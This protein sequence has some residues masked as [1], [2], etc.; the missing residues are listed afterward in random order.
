V[1]PI[2]VLGAADAEQRARGLRQ[3]EI[4]RAHRVA[5]RRDDGRVDGGVGKVGRIGVTAT[6]TATASS[7]RE[8]DSGREHVR[9]NH[10]GSV[11]AHACSCHPEAATSPPTRTGVDATRRLTHM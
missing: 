11:P 6:A 4:G 10:G 7:Q 9:A 2:A 8:A 5:Q 1:A 3:L